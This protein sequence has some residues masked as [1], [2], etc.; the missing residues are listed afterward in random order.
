MPLEDDDTTCR[1]ALDFTELMM[2]L[3]IRSA[4]FVGEQSCPYHEEFDGNDLTAT[5]VLAFVKQ[6][7]VGTMRIR[8]FADFVKL[9]RVCIRKEYRGRGIFRKLCSFVGEFVTSKGY[10]LGTLH[11]H[12]ELLSVWQNASFPKPAKVSELSKTSLSFSGMNFLPLK[13]EFPA[14][15]TPFSLETDA[16]IL[17]RPEG[18]WAIPGVLEQS[19]G[20]IRRG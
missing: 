7:P 4:V 15:A 18:R 20:R 10:R 11:A 19:S 9:E 14:H 3:A 8:Y 13:V 1:V 2:A 6:E 16:N 12:D 5:H 17:N